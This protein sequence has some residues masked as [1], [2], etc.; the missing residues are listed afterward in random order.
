VELPASVAQ[1]DLWRLQRTEHQTLEFKDAKASF[2]FDKLNAYCV[3]IA[4]EGGGHLILGISDAPPRIVVGS[5]AFPDLVETADRLFRAV[6][7]RV[8]VEEVAHPNGRVVVF[9]I[10]SRP[11]GTAYHLEG[12]YLMRSGQSLAPMSEDRLR[13]IFA[14]GAPDWLEDPALRGL[15]AQ[16]VID[17]LDTQA[18]FDLLRQPYPTN[19]DLVLDRL[20]SD[21]LIDRDVGNYSIRRLGALL[22]AK[23]LSAFLDVARKAPRVIVYSGL[24]KLEPR[25][26]QL[27]VRGSTASER[28]Y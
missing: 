13:A 9:Q 14:E 23:R 17:L 20:G 15:D 3:A 1:I 18:Y 25:Q 24:S 12:K 22:L 4:N 27:G 19:R 26:D 2:A 21:R 7:F 5:H 6:G 11:L 8:E 28:N 10:P 16:A